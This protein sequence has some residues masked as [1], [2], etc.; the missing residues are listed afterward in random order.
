MNM[1]L[2]HHSYRSSLIGILSASVLLS[3]S[4]GNVLAD[5][6][7]GQPASHLTTA[8]SH[9]HGQ[10]TTKEV[11]RTINYV[12]PLTKEKHTINQVVR[13][14][15]D[16]DGKL[17][18]KGT[19]SAWQAYFV[20]Y[21]EGYAPNWCEVPPKVITPDSANETEDVI[22]TK[23]LSENPIGSVLI[24]FIP[25]DGSNVQYLTIGNSDGK[26]LSTFELPEPPEGWKYVGKDQLPKIVQITP[27]ATRFNFL[28][29]KNDTDTH[30]EK[31][32]ENKELSRK[33]IL[34]LPTGDKVITQHARATRDVSV[35]DG[36]NSYGE[37]QISPFDEFVL[38]Q[39]DGYQSSLTKVASLQL[40]A[41]QLEKE[42]V[43]IK[44]DYHKVNDE[45]TSTDPSKDASTETDPVP[46]V[47]EGTQT[48]P[49][50][51][52][53]TQTDP[54]AMSDAG[55][56]TEPSTGKDEGTQT[57]QPT[58]EDEGNQTD[59]TPTVD[60]GVGDDTIT[61]TDEGTQT[62]HPTKSDEG[63]QT[64]DTPTIDTGV[65][66]D[67]IAGTDQGTQTD[68]P[69]KA[70]EGSQTIDTPTT[71][72]GVGDDSIAGTDQ[73]TQTE[74]STNEDQSAQTGTTKDDQGASAVPDQT[75]TQPTIQ[76]KAKGQ[77]AIDPVAFHNELN[78]LQRPLKELA[79]SPQ[80]HQAAVLPQ[81]GNQTNLK[82]FLTG[83][84]TVL[85]GALLAMFHLQKR[86]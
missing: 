69:A 35:V 45:G 24:K 58:K 41:D 50:I 13:F 75:S 3:L 64:I 4:A 60:T 29:Q 10:V 7:T 61:G 8:K 11:T 63:S 77:D 79:T 54:P 59:D 85:T 22:Y 30:Q 38:P 33:I 72:T 76:E 18:K 62:D 40:T 36:K 70:D 34:H 57:D 39:V 23:V 9:D 1:K 81:T 21:F 86:H 15:F 20:P 68:Q 65:G 25:I 73:G 56:Q 46:G 74:P 32:Q 71:D 44:V 31:K 14:Q 27:G 37:W 26:P 2:S 48:D 5:A 53:G 51:S 17:I 6:N 83:I 78:Q 80:H 52:T 66:D 55:T 43:T 47:D 16:Q 12:D 67:S 84:L 49:S 82:V 42:P 28:I 19:V